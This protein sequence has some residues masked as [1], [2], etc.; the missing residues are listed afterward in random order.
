[1]AHKVTNLDTAE[2]QSPR[3]EEPVARTCCGQVAYTV[4][5][6]NADAFLKNGEPSAAAQH[7]NQKKLACETD[8]AAPE[9]KG[10]G[11]LFRGMF[12]GSK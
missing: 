7:F 3:E 9:K 11:G 12:G 6:N 2:Q 1:M 8:G 5:K 10:I 4:G